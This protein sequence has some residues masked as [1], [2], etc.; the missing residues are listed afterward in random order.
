MEF[1]S[2]HSGSSECVYLGEWCVQTW[3]WFAEP[4]RDHC[5]VLMAGTN[6]VAVGRNDIIFARLDDVLISCRR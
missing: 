3:G 2:G 1:G 4:P 6:D 5:Y